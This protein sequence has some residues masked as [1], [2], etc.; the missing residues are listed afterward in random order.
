MCIIYSP[1]IRH[2]WNFLS[3]S[4]SSTSMVEKVGGKLPE[5]RKQNGIKHLRAFLV[6]SIKQEE[7]FIL[8]ME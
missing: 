8:N 7:G 6:D 4:S 3:R 2:F 5:R 1:S